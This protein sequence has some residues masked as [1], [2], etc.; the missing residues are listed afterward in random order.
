MIKDKAFTAAKNVLKIAF[1]RLTNDPSYRNKTYH[2]ED[3]ELALFQ[4]CEAWDKIVNNVEGRTDPFV[5]QSK[6]WVDEWLSGMMNHLSSMKEGHQPLM[7]INALEFIITKTYEFLGSR[8]QE[9]VQK[10]FSSSWKVMSNYSYK[11]V[12]VDEELLG[13]ESPRLPTYIPYDLT[14]FIHEKEVKKLN[15]GNNQIAHEIMER[16]KEAWRIRRL[17]VEKGFAVDN[18]MREKK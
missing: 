8:K 12:W 6:K 13:T 9:D 2:G 16:I 11:T 7:H 3:F 17:A 18:Y 15:L 5:V 4:F 14:E 1:D 10:V